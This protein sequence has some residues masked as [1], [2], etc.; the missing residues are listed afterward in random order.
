VSCCSAAVARFR[1]ERHVITAEKVC[2]V[3]GRTFGRSAI[4]AENVGFAVELDSNS[5]RTIAMG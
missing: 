3:G 5:S 1:A 4:E 2:R